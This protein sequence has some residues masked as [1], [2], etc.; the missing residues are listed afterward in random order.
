M[1][2]T[3][4]ITNTISMTSTTTSVISSSSTSSTINPSSI[5][6]TT[7]STFCAVVGGGV[8][9]LEAVHLQGGRAL[10]VVPG[11]GEASLHRRRVVCATTIRVNLCDE[12]EPLPRCLSHPIHPVAAEG[13]AGAL[14]DQGQGPPRTHEPTA[15]CPSSPGLRAALMLDESGGGLVSPGGSLTLVCKGSGFTFSYYGMSWVRQ[16]P[17]KGLEY[18][19]G[20]TDSGGYT[21]YASAVK[22]RFTISRNNGQS[23]LCALNVF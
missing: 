22:G 13:E 23:T 17:G 21:E 18:V 1:I 19:A 12:L 6:T 2:F 5:S 3:K 8:F 11:D 4:T 9:G 15:L 14:A 20:I 10:P 16:A 7:T